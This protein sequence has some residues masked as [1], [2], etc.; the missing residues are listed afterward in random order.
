MGAHDPSTKGNDPQAD[1]EREK[2]LEIVGMMQI[3]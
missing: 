1:S 2:S 3:G